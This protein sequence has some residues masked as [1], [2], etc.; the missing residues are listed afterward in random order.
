MNDA[1][2][3]P[4]AGMR[5]AGQ[6][7][8]AGAIRRDLTVIRTLASAKEFQQARELCATLLADQQPLIARQRDLLSETFA[9][10]IVIRGFRFL[11][12][13]AMAALG[14]DVRVTARTGCVRLPASLGQ[15]VEYG[16][17]VFT[18]DTGSDDS[19]LEESTA[20]YWAEIILS[21]S[22][23]GE[24]PAADTIADRVTKVDPYVHTEP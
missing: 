13:L 10:L 22:S 24:Q 23:G 20:W 14:Q 2:P 17:P 19:P 15:H 12:R 1:I 21:G 4:V 16:C 18:F 11:S 8:A 5:V 6:R 7:D 9:T 3:R